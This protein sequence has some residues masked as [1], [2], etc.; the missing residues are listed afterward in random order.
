MD[1][2]EW[3][4]KATNC[5]VWLSIKIQVLPAEDLNITS[6]QPQPTKAIMTPENLITTI[7][8]AAMPKQM[9]DGSLAP[10][11]TVDQVEQLAMRFGTDGKTVEIAAFENSV[12]PER[13]VRNFSTFT[14]A[15][16]IR[17]LKSHITV[18]GLG[19]LGGT[20]TEYLARAGVGHL[21]LVDGDQFEDHN[22][23]R[24]TLCTQDRLGQPKARSA[25]E[26]VCRINSSLTVQAFSEYL[27]D[28]NADRYIAGSHVVVDCLDNIDS[29][30]TLQSA[31]RQAKIP[32][33]SAAVGGLCGHITTI[34][35]QDQGLELI[36]GASG[37]RTSAK[38][39]ET[40]LGCLPQ[41]VGLIAAA[42]SAEV[43]KVLLD[44][45]TLQNKMLVVDVTTHT[46]E[47]LALK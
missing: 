2:N 35:P 45:Q 44:Q 36:Y 28:E 39:A 1:A 41:A 43:I 5:P 9:P 37:Q 42:E 22:L 6:R 20:V 34:Y 24:Q 46:Y 3:D 26:R 38:G 31:A 15:E 33:V 16:Q 12:F 8:K 18:V 23:N 19:G 14:T 29:R 27:T 47:V 4:L 21:N 30:F 7:E 25:A 32:M 40:V 11:L 17:L 10:I 13:Y